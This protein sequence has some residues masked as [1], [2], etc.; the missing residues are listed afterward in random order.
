MRQAKLIF[1]QI[2]LAIN[3]LKEHNLVH[4]DIKDENIVVDEKYMIKLIDFGSCTQIPQQRKDFFL[5]YK[6]TPHFA[7]PEIVRG[8]PYQGP[9]AEI[10]YSVIIGLLEY[11]CTRLHL[12]KIHSKQMMIS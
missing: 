3:H 7:S 4:R 5:S 11:C 1:A 10:W 8:T 6:G 12:V 9:Q 2:L